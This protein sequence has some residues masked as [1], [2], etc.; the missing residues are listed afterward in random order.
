VE[1]EGDAQDM[2]LRVAG[3]WHASISRDSPPRRILNLRAGKH[4]HN[5]APSPC[6]LAGFM[7]QCSID[8]RTN[9]TSYKSSGARSPPRAKHQH[10]PD[11][12]PTPIM[13]S[14]TSLD[15]DMRKLRMDR[16]T[17]KAAN[18]VRAWIEDALGDRLPAGDLLDA[19]KDGTVLCRYMSTT[20]E[21][22]VS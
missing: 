17:P 7:H 1:G 5:R 2:T 20:P 14:V 12:R 16:Y 15:Q 4:L 11:L 8:Y 10:Q 9:I 3:G 22:V 6:I 19:L 18:E 13:A 21:T